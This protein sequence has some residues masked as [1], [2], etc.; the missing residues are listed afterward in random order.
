M[1]LA[2][3]NAHVNTTHFCYE[4]DLGVTTSTHSM[5][6]IANTPWRDPL[7]AQPRG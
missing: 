2:G 1:P 7:P 5:S 6:A 3:D 4:R